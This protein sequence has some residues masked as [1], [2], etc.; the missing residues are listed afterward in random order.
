MDKIRQRREIS[1]KYKWSLDEVYQSEKDLDSDIKLVKEKTKE[2]KK[3]KTHILD[4][5]DNLLKSLD[6]YMDISRLNSKL[7]IYANMK[8][9]EDT[10]VNTY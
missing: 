10:R 4:N 3:L 8:C 6:L 9:H 5:P 1:D 7:F 2:L